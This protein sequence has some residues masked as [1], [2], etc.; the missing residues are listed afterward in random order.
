M[1]LVD[2][3]WLLLHCFSLVAYCLGAWL[4]LCVGAATVVAA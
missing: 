4:S 3:V 2:H 1:L